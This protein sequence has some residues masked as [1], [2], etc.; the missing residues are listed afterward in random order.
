VDSILVTWWNLG[1]A[2]YLLCML[3]KQHTGYGNL[4]DSVISMQSSQNR[5]DSACSFYLSLG[6][7]VHDEYVHDNGLSLTDPAFQGAVG[8]NPELWV[9]PKREAVSFLQCIVGG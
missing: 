3:V 8:K 5:N 7:W 1:L 6:F 9:S 2:T 4:A